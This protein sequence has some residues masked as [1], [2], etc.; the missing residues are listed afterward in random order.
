MKT[1]FIKGDNRQN[2]GAAKKLLILLSV[3]AINAYAAHTHRVNQQKL[4]ISADDTTEYSNGEALYSGNVELTRGSLVVYGSSGDSSKYG[5]VVHIY[6][7]PVTYERQVNGKIIEGS[8]REVTYYKDSGK[9]VLNGNPRFI[10]GEEEVVGYGDEVIIY[11]TDN[12][13]VKVVD[14]ETVVYED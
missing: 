4:A 10:A 12:N 8:A 5:R 3:F 14:V 9:L 6:G 11:N 7:N 1:L 2:F 13:N